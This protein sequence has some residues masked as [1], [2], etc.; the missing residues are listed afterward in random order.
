M[1][2]ETHVFQVKLLYLFGCPC[3]RISLFFFFEVIILQDR[4]WISWSLQLCMSN[5]PSNIYSLPACCSTVQFYMK[6]VTST[7]ESELSNRFC[8]ESMKDA[9]T[10]KHGRRPIKWSV[11]LLCA[12]L[13]F[14]WCYFYILYFSLSGIEMWVQTLS[15][16]KRYCS[17]ILSH[18]I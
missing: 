14:I 13:V 17:I 8:W 2:A 16:V 5:L 6:S 9:R 12:V 7:Q 15:L 18:T 1:K 4:G 3:S 11:H 10:V